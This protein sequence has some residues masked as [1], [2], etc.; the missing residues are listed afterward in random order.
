MLRLCRS[1]GLP[2]PESNQRIAGERVDFVWREERLVIE[3]DGGQAHLTAA[4]FENDRRRDVELM[5]AGWRVGRFTWAAVAR[6]PDRVADRLARL[7][8]QAVPS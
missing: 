6:E 7:L 5:I 1:A 2:E 8:G 4:A 3:T